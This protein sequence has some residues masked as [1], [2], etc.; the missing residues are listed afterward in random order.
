MHTQRGQKDSPPP[1]LHL[2]TEKKNPTEVISGRLWTLHE[3][4]LIA[5][6]TLFHILTLKHVWTCLFLTHPHSAALSLSYMGVHTSF[7]TCSHTHTIPLAARL[8]LTV[9]KEQWITISWQ[10]VDPFPSIPDAQCVASVWARGSLSGLS[11]SFCLAC[12]A[13]C[14][15]WLA[16][17]CNPAHSKLHFFIFSTLLP[18]NFQI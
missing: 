5:W 10:K 18:N 9:R 11:C 3:Y 17:S 7:N 16:V 13:W 15:Q 8:L 14:L 1:Q 2:H 4:D 12:K 6:E